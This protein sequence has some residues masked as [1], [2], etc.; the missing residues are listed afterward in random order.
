MLAQ[1]VFQRFGAWRS[2]GFRSGPPKRHKTVN[3]PQKLM[4]DKMF[5]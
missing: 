5:N 1:Y 2:G 3:T 4:R